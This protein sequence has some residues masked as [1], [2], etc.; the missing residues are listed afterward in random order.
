MMER[1]R[2]ISLGAVNG[3]KRGVL[4]AFLLAIDL[5]VVSWLS[6]NN[7]SMLLVN[8]FALVKSPDSLPQVF[9]WTA[10]VLMTLA[11]TG[12]GCATG[13]FM[14]HSVW[15]I[16]GGALGGYSFAWACWGVFTSKQQPGNIVPHRRAFAQDQ[17]IEPTTG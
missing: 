11:I 15:G 9:I 8:R 7:R 16:V 6:G 10:C 12:V 1:I 3:I 13:Y 5:C 4:I 14:S 17:E 2:R